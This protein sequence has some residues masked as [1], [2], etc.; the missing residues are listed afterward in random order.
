[1]CSIPTEIRIRSCRLLVIGHQ[2]NIGGE[3]YLSDTR[4]ALLLIGELL[5]S[6]APWVNSKCLGIANIGQVRNKLEAI[7]N[8]TSSTT[9]LDTKAQNTTEALLE[10]L[11][12]RLMVRVALE[13]RVR[14]PADIRALLKILSKGE[15][16]LGMTF[17]TETESL[18]TEE[19][20]LSGE[21]V[22]S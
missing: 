18:E 22:E 3:T 17:S 4:A 10:V 2:S 16:V 8:L 13:T 20:L 7:N 12:S 11:L 6:G 19:E 14:N 15:S 5:V 1:M 9:T 21:G